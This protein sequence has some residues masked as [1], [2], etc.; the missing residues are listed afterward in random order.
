MADRVRANEHR[1][2]I[3]VVTEYGQIPEITCFPEQLNQV[4]LNILAN[5]IDAL[6]ESNQGRSFSEIKAS[7]NR[8][9]I[10]TQMTNDKCVT[11]G[12]SDNGIG[13]TEEVKQQ[14]FDRLFTTKAVGRGTG[15]GMAIAK[16]IV[17][18]KHGGRINVNS[19]LGGGSE[20]E[21]VLPITE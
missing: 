4:F 1:P 12:I 3:K 11:I 16:S 19:T 2:A 20:F 21:I 10:R 9:T 18:E 8:I 14:I 15:L 7:P 13:M 6:A 17:V 5:A